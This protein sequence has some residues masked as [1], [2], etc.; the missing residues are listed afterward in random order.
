VMHDDRP[1]KQRYFPKNPKMQDEINKQIDE[2]L[3]KGCIE[4]STVHTVPRL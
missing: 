1:I 3:A 4:P 2:L